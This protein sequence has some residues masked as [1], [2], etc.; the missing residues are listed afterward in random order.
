[1]KTKIFAAAVVLYSLNGF[2]ADNTLDVEGL[3]RELKELRQRTEQLEKK[4]QVIERG[5]A[6]PAVATNQP[7]VA[8]LVA[9]AAAA[10]PPPPAPAPQQKWS[11]SEPLTLARA[12]GSY[13]NLS[14]DVLADAGWSTDPRPE[15]K[16]QLADHDPKQRGFTLSGAEIALDGNVDP[17]FKGFANILF[18]LDSH[19][20]TEVELEEAYLQS[21]SLPGNIQVKA[22][23]MLA[24]F[25]RQNSQH[26]HQW[27][28]VDFPIIMTRAFGPDGLRNPGAQISY[29]LPTP[30]FAEA[31]LGILNGQSD[32]A[33]S[34]R[35]PG[36]A[37]SFGIDRVH[38]RETIDRNLRSPGDLVY[39]PRLATSFDL[40][41]NQTLVL[42]TSGAFGPNDT[43]SH[44]R[45]E[46]YGVDA[47]WKWKPAK[48]HLGFPF[49]SFQTE[50]LYQRFGAAADPLAATPLPS[51]NL[52]DWGFYSQVLWGFHDRW[53]AG[54]RGEYA[55]GNSGG[56]DSNDPFRNER[57]RI[58][59]NLTW[60]PSEFSK[61]RLQYNLDHGEMVGDEHSVWLQVEFLIGAHA[62]HKF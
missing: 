3:K 50:G 61:I 47:Y 7:A 12:G 8:P 10:P 18:K 23:Q 19:A 39:V 36:E 21:T 1:M 44:E 27:A 58:S 5:A 25:G 14:M 49:V 42:G 13:L 53:V 41:D 16:L 24:N 45:T 56:F 60:Y 33:F 22:G 26:A 46:I 35:N 34:F 28:F 37:D 4:L 51:E 2:S 31:S 11:P 29:L 55:S 40:T 15:E 59:P 57:T 6:V 48:S 9:P 54:L 32:Q 52:R 43:G 20:E 30:F 62:A 17:Y 38:G